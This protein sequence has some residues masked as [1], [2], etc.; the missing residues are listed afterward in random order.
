M[1]YGQLVAAHDNTCVTY[2]DEASCEATLGKGQFLQLD[3][4]SPMP[5]VVDCSRPC[6]VAVFNRGHLADLKNTNSFMM[7]VPDVTQRLNAPI[8]FYTFTYSNGNEYR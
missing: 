5:A 6:L 2:G 4:Y 3:M 1:V 8:D 7:L